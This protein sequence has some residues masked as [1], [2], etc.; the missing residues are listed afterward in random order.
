MSWA[1]E[2]EPCWD[3]LMVR[4]NSFGSRGIPVSISSIVSSSIRTSFLICAINLR[5]LFSDCSSKVRVF[6]SHINFHALPK[7]SRISCTF[8][9]SLINGKS[10]LWSPRI[11]WRIFSCPWWTAKDTITTADG[12]NWNFLSSDRHMSISR[13]NRPAYSGCTAAVFCS[14][15]LRSCTSQG[16][17]IWSPAAARW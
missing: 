2:F 17:S 5:K 6:I 16:R 15:G 14:A 1:T 11:F 9:K 8:S 10:R 4:V 13:T 12:K 3:I 7:F